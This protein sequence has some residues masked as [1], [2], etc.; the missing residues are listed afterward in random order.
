MGQGFHVSRL[1]RV[2]QARKLSSQAILR[3]TEEGANGREQTIPFYL[4]PFLLV[5]NA[6]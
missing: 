2:W 5:L 4:L 6:F 1:L 3:D